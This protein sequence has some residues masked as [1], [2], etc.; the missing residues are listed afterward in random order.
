MRLALLISLIMV[1]FAANS[2][3][4]RAGVSD[5]ADPMAFA[6]VR[7]WAGALTLTVLALWRA[8]DLRAAHADLKGRTLGALALG[9]YLVG[10][11]VSSQWL[12]AG[13]GALILF[14]TVQVTLFSAALITGERTTARKW[15]GMVLAMS[16]LV[17]LLWPQGEGPPG[18]TSV[19]G[20]V[21]MGL[22]GL[23][24]GAYTWLGRQAGPP[25]P[26]TA[27]NFTWVALVF[28]ALWLG[29]LTD[30]MS[31][32][33]LALAIASGA[34]ASGL[35]YA[36]WFAVLPQISATTAGVS[37]L[38]VPVIA[39]LGGAVFLGEVITAQVLLACT[40]VLGGIAFATVQPRKA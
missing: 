27:A 38:S 15:I 2:V 35:G 20:P 1:A 28:A 40:V 39:V 7:V 17:W 26:V 13:I 32:S 10:F 11:S 30:E 33:Q 29:G 21:F 4:T 16:G 23:G 8:K 5:G 24:W 31:T 25:L 18:V 22:G 19:L 34:I 6:L 37:Q 36:L 3:L 14:G 12:E 9:V